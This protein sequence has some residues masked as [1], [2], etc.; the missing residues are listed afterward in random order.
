MGPNLL[1]GSWG[2]QIHPTGFVFLKANSGCSPSD[3]GVD[4]PYSHIRNCSGR[5]RG[6]KKYGK[7][8]TPSTDHCSRLLLIK[9]ATC[10]DRLSQRFSQHGTSLKRLGSSQCALLVCKGVIVSRE[11]DRICQFKWLSLVK[12]VMPNGDHRCWEDV[13]L[14]PNRCVLGTCFST[15]RWWNGELRSLQSKLC[16]DADSEHKQKA[17]D[18]SLRSKTCLF[19]FG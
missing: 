11:A 3:W 2:L 5:K 15:H 16:L 19:N 10:D 13:F 9:Q 8:M 6:E 14:L 1:G 18:V 4:Q 7:V 17:G 12:K